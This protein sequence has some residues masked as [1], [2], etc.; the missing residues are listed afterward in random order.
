M[1]SFLS[2]AHDRLASGSK[3]KSIRIWDL[4]TGECLITFKTYVTC[5]DELQESNTRTRLI[6]GSWNK[7]ILVWDLE[8]KDYTKVDTCHTRDISCLKTLKNGARF[9]SGSFDNTIKIWKVSTL[10]CV[11]TLRGHC[12]DVNYLEVNTTSTGYS[13]LSSH[14][15]LISCSDDKTIRVWN[16]FPNHSY[17]CL[18]V[19]RGH[20][21]A[22]R[23][24]KLNAYT[25][26]LYSVSADQ[27]NYCDHKVKVWDLDTG[28]CL[29]VIQT[30]YYIHTLELC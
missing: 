20:L 9:A 7:S 22:V 8:N 13:L 30:S 27:E 4:V 16:L 11:A 15:Q 25:G 14:E 12:G 17:Q 18:R 10:E 21:N 3:D 24:I 6:S 28:K 23:L 1:I 19:L 2:K 29:R 26:E 5:L